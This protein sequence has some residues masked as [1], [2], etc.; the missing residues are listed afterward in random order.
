M[1]IELAIS[2]YG[3]VEGEYYLSPLSV[4]SGRAAFAAS[5]FRYS[6]EVSFASSFAHVDVI[7]ATFM[8][9]S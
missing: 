2:Y 9:Y 5:S 4:K 3:R 6:L 1:V 8:D 7:V